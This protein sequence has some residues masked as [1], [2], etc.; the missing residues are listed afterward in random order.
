M[1]T[2]SKSIEQLGT[3]KLGIV[4]ANIIHMRR[5]M[6]PESI[7]HVLC[8]GHLL[9]ERVGLVCGVCTDDLDRTPAKPGRRTPGF[10]QF[11]LAVNRQAQNAVMCSASRMMVWAGF[12]EMYA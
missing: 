10:R 9:R 3:L 12:W 4:D 5:F 1:T 7:H 8:D 2:N 11:R 6:Q